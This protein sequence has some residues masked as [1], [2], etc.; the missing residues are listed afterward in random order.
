[1]SHSTMEHGT[2]STTQSMH[3]GFTLSY[4]GTI[5]LFDSWAPKDDG[6]FVGAICAIIAIA[7]LFSAMLALRNIFER[8]WAVYWYDKM[9]FVYMN[10]ETTTQ[11]TQ[12][13]PFRMQVEIPRMLITFVTVALGYALMLIVMTYVVV[14]HMSMMQANLTGLLLRSLLWPRAW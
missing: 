14:F 9:S 8:T 2:T 10:P 4:A 1:M 11:W 7:V 12:S 3:S 13:A 5:I 6:A